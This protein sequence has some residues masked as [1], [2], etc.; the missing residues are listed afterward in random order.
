[1]TYKIIILQYRTDS[2][3]WYKKVDDVSK[4]DSV[5]LSTEQNFC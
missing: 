2:P 3:Y 1:M 5:D 4:H